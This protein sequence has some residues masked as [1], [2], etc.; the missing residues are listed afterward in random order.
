MRVLFGLKEIEDDDTVA[1]SDV[2]VKQGKSY[3]QPS[4]IYLP[5]KNQQYTL[6][7][8]DPDVDFPEILHWMVTNIPEDKIDKGLVIM[9][10]APSNPHDDKPH[11]YIFVLYKQSHEIEPSDILDRKGFNHK[12]FQED[13]ELKEVETFTYHTENP[14]VLRGKRYKVFYE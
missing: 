12:K 3:L 4:V 11:R 14:Q 2:R 9:P 7:M 13:N 6:I 1:L 5:D 8:Y 10:F